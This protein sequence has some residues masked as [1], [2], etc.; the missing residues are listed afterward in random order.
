MPICR[1]PVRP[2]VFVYRNPDHKNTQLSAICNQH[3]RKYYEEY[4][5]TSVFVSILTKFSVCSYEY[6][7]SY[8]DHR[9]VITYISR[10]LGAIQSRRDIQ[11]TRRSKIRRG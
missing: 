10:P 7:C 8:G 2:E 11:E 5:P 3:V 1:S 4:S 6:F 9:D